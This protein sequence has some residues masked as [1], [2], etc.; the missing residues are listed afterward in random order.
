[1]NKWLRFFGFLAL[2]CILY[3][4]HF[5]PNLNHFLDSFFVFQDQSDANVY[6]WN[7]WHFAEQVK[8]GLNPFFTE[9]MF[10]PLGASLWMHAYTLFFGVINLV[11]SNPYL[12]I[13]LGIAMHFV[14][15]FVGFVYLANYFLQHYGWAIMVATL[16]TFNT[17]FL[18]KAGVH[19][20]LVL[21]ASVPWVLWFALRVYSTRKSTALQVFVVAVGVL[22][23]ALID[24]YAA[25][26]ILFSLVIYVLWKY[27]L[28]QWFTKLNWEKVG[29]LGALLVLGHIIVRLLRLKGLDEKGALWAAA[30]FKQLFLPTETSL[31]F[32]DLVSNTALFPND[33]K[34]FIGFGLLLF[35]I[36][37]VVVYLTEKNP[38]SAQLWLFASVILLFVVAPVVKIN[39]KDVWYNVT[40]LVHFVPF[41]NHVRAPD[42]FVPLLLFAMAMFTSS[43]FLSLL[44]DR[45]VS[46]VL[47]VLFIAFAWISHSQVKMVAIKEKGALS[48][49][50]GK[51]LKQFEPLQESEVSSALFIPFGARDG[52]EKLGHFNA[53]APKYITRH[54]VKMVGGYL[55]RV[56]QE[57]WEYYKS[58]A[59]LNKLVMLQNGERIVLRRNEV[60][61]AIKE[62]EVEAIC[63][64]KMN[65]IDFP[66]LH[67]ALFPILTDSSFLV[68]DNSFIAVF[69]PKD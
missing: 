62:L 31:L 28:K 30:D 65:S 43:V 23:S 52:Y 6:L 19:Y 16:A 61:N 64:S 7:T 20:N 37:S 44:K 59:F 60:I 34:L 41:V 45:V 14:L 39:S 46:Y 5:Y 69:R 25:F 2:G 35:F 57:N 29:L 42:R 9:Y 54:N 27:V 50:F 26:Y 21:M 12:A 32:Q 63:Y 4:I 48:N 33:N 3:V 36:A 53:F 56:P 22:L 18:A 13:N 55:S 68:Y 8:D 40:A 24:Y 47:I 11:V 1:M 49:L 67:E 10:Y 17:Y 66:E 15:M 38:K 51:D 58:N